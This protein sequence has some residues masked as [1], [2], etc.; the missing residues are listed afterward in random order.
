[1]SDTPNFK[2][3]KYTNHE[4]QIAMVNDLYSGTDKT[5][6]YLRQFPKEKNN[7]YAERQQDSALDSF[8]FSTID[9]MKNII[10]RKNID[11]TGIT[12]TS[13][14][15]WCKAIDFTLPLNEFAKKILTNRAKDGKTYILVDRM[16]FDKEKT[17]NASQQ[18]DKDKRPY[19]VNVLREN[20]LNIKYD[21]YGNFERVSI[22]E[23]YSENVGMFGSKTS[24][25]IKVWYSN[26]VVQIWREDVLHETIKT[27]LTEIP[28]IEIG[29]DDNPP[30][31]NQSKQNIQHYNRSAECANYVRLGASPFLAVFGNIDGDSPATLGINSGLKFSSKT[32]SDIKWIEMTGANYDIISKEIL[33][34]EEQMLRIAVQYVTK[35]QNKTA[36]QVEKESMSG[37]SKLNDYSTEVE[38]GINKSLELMQLFSQANLGKNTITTNKDFDSSIL[39]PEQAASYRNDYVQ[40]IISIDTLWDLYSKGEY[41]PPMD[42]KEKEKEKVLLRDSGE[43]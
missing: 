33:K 6:K 38:E 4:H 3:K 32:D 31:Y 18:K 19:F 36:T 13:V 8:V 30:L 24:E 27:G 16:F 37:E 21:E 40:G 17:L 42:E 28:L 5:V 34:L 14:L 11:L 2:D 26:G 39:T 43:V 7:L 35:S 10:F 9:T 15:E 29:N 25:Q 12:N 20:I 22:R 41:I 23:F 1:M